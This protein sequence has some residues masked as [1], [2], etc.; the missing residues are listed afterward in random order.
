MFFLF[1]FQMM[2]Y[3]LS[4]RKIWW[5]L[6]SIEWETTSLEAKIVWMQHKCLVHINKVVCSF[7]QAILCSVYWM[8]IWSICAKTRCFGKAIYHHFP[9]VFQYASERYPRTRNI[10]GCICALII[11]PEA[12]QWW[13]IIFWKCTHDFCTYRRVNSSTQR[14]YGLNRRQNNS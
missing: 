13:Y 5:M 14:P 11:N 8:R 12:H 9:R 3:S 6:D 4:E 1:L 7:F 10:S 2:S